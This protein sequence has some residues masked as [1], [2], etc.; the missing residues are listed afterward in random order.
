[1]ER[2]TSERAAATAPDESP[3]RWSDL[4]IAI[5]DG[6]GTLTLHRPEHRNAMSTT[7]LAELHEATAYLA[8]EASLKGLLI[9]GA[10]DS[11]SSG[12]D[13][14]TIRAC[15]NDETADVVAVS[16]KQVSLLQQAIVNIRRMS[17]PVVAAVNGLAAGSGFGLALACDDRVASPRARFMAAYGAVGLTPDAGLTYFLPRIV[18]DARAL[19]IIVGDRVVRAKQ[20]E[21]LGLVSE[22]IEEDELEIAAMRRLRRLTRLAPR[23]VA[24]TKL[25]LQGTWHEGFADHLQRERE[26]FADACATNDFREGIEAIHAGRKPRFEGS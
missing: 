4:R 24:A 8:G 1:M 13:L 14:D 15:L 5:A 25:L 11:F 22:V 17:F 19:A 6:W 23:S 12:G 20:A 3:S 10:G 2:E 21:Q 16:R 18:G 7:M 9:T 26:L